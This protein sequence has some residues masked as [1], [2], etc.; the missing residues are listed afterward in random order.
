M[1]HKRKVGQSITRK[2]C[3]FRSIRNIFYE[4][5]TSIKFE[6]RRLKLYLLR[7]MQQYL[8]CEMKYLLKSQRQRKHRKLDVGPIPSEVYFHAVA[9]IHFLVNDIAYKQFLI[10]VL[11]KHLLFIVIYLW[12]KKTLQFS[13]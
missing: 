9:I 3:L 11:F 13:S 5:T 12:C 6:T 7:K 10:S 8:N 2:K 4:Q 1:Q